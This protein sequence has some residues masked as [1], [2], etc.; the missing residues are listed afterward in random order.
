MS[1]KK[2]KNSGV[3]AD[4]LALFDKLIAINP[5]IERKGANNAYAAVNGADCAQRGD[6]A[7]LGTRPALCLA[8]AS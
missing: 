5:E 7:R 3:P 6:Y 1:T 8:F 2:A 4:E